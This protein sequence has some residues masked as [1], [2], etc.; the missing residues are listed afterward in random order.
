MLELLTWLSKIEAALAATLSPALKKAS[1]RGAPGHLRKVVAG[2]RKL[3]G[4]MRSTAAALKKE[5]VRTPAISGIKG[6][7]EDVDSSLS[8]LAEAV[9]SGM[10]GAELAEALALHEY[11]KWNNLFLAL[12]GVVREGFPAAIPM[13][14]RA[15]RNKR[16]VERFLE[17][18][19]STQGLFRLRSSDPAWRERFL[20]VGQVCPSVEAALISDGIVETIPDG[21]K[22]IER[23]KERYYGVLVADDELPDIRALELCRR[24]ARLFPGIE[25]RFLFL[26]SGIEEKSRTRGK[27]KE[28]RRIQKSATRD[29]ILEEV[30]LILDR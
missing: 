1:C 6:A 29:R 9:S 13:L 7:K 21:S 3:S 23:L 15:Q 4:T 8:L 20:L 5:R 22:A 24:A 16:A 27:G 19:G 18:E 10:D 12:S 25:D 14:A 17:H 30:G 26:Y 28:P 11:L 2:K